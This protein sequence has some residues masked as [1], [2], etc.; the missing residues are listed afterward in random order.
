[1]DKKRVEIICLDTLVLPACARNLP[2]L[3]DERGEMLES[4][5][6]SMDVWIHVNFFISSIIIMRI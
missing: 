1:M 5:I 3:T 4:S 6:T 2:F